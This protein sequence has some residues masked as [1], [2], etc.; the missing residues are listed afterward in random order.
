MRSI[1]G[2]LLKST[3]NPPIKGGVPVDITV[4]LPDELGERAKR[5]EINLSRML[6]DA[7]T[8]EFERSDTMS[9]TLNKPETY[10]LELDDDETGQY[11]GR[12]TGKLIAEDDDV[13]VYL[14]ERERVIV[15]DGSLLRYHDITDDPEEGLSGLRHAAYTDACRALGINPVVDLDL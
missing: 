1:H 4:Y 12:I 8:E 5:D 2:Y 14:T 7:L 13:A 3:G 10:E 6:R 9:K 15:Y 11:T